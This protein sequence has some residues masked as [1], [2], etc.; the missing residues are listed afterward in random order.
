MHIAIIGNGITGVTAA[1][2]IRKLNP[3]CRISI[4][5]SESKYFYSRTALMYIYMGHMTYNHT[6][7]YEDNFWEK[8]RLDLIF[9][10]VNSIDFEKR[11]LILSEKGEVTYDK[12]LLATG[13]KSNK[14]EVPGINLDGVQ[15][16]YS[17]QDLEKLEM[18]THPP[19]T[20]KE[21]QKVKNAVIVGGGLIGVELAEMLISRNI[22][23]TFLIREKRFWGSVLPEEEA[24]I[25]KEQ[26]KMHG[27]TMIFEDEL[28]EIKSDENGRV[29]EVVSV[30]SQLISCEFVGLTIGVSPNV[31]F[32]KNTDLKINR[33]ILVNRNFETNIDGVFAAG[34]CCEFIEPVKGRKPIEQVWYTGRI[35]GEI[36]GNNILGQKDEYNPGPWY[37][38]AKFF[39]IEYQTYG[40]VNSELL[41]DESKFYF[42]SPDGKNCLKLI[43][44]KE[45][46]KL[47]GVNSLGFRLRHEII[48]Q[49]LVEEKSVVTFI[50][51][52]KKIHFNPEFS[53][54]YEK[55]IQKKF[56]QDFGLNT[57]IKTGKWKLFA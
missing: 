9:D 44:K 35:M 31:E 52:W 51:N 34:D 10:H 4:I 11:K 19:K 39:D 54:N 12:L 28:K 47:L 37:N 14:F 42:E 1:R 21:S 23:V 3:D 15:G 18:N 5:S 48:E 38:S 43:F 2:T 8:N 50:E 13:S 6:K 53:E 26:L 49:M 27:V 16:L 56:N 7:P 36:A 20:N 33:G 46:M 57:N 45:T 29:K 30:R 41:P 24:S 55:A 25:I 40:N 17:F 22:E 32:L